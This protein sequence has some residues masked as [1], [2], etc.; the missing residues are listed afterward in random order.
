[1]SETRRRQTIDETEGAFRALDGY[2][3]AL[4]QGSDASQS[5]QR[6]H[7]P[8][9]DQ[10]QQDLQMLESLYDAAEMLRQDSLATDVDAAEH[11]DAPRSLLAPGTM[12]DQCRIDHLLGIGGMGEVY[13]AQHQVLACRVAVKVM[14]RQL[15][16]A[17]FLDRFRKEIQALA[18]VT[19]HPNITAAMHA[20]QYEDR[21][22][23]VTEYVDGVDLQ[24]LIHRHGPLPADQACRYI[25]QA[26]VG[27]A[28]AH[29]RGVV[30]R[31]IKPSNLM[32][33]DDDQIKILDMGLASIH[34][35][36][37]G[38]SLAMT[39]AGSLLGTLD[40]IAPEQIENPACAD[41]RS[42]L[43][44]LGCTFY[45]LLAGRPPYANLTPLQKISAHASQHPTS[46][47]KLGRNIPTSVIV[48]VETLMAKRPQDRYA[49]S[50]QLVAVLDGLT[51]QADEQRLPQPAGAARP[52]GMATAA[53]P[54]KPAGRP[55][56]RNLIAEKKRLVA[57]TAG[58]AVAVVVTATILWPR[59][60]DVT[61]PVESPAA[62]GL[63]TS[64][65]EEEPAPPIPLQRQ[66][67]RL[68]HP[69]VSVGQSLDT[70]EGT[71]P[72]ATSE[73]GRA[74]LIYV[75]STDSL[76]IRGDFEDEVHWYL[77]ATRDQ[78]GM[79]MLAHGNAEKRLAASDVIR[80][81]N[82]SDTTRWK[83][84]LLV[85]GSIP[86]DQADPYLQA[87]FQDVQG[88]L[89][90]L[91]IGVSS[92][93]SD[94][95]SSAEPQAV[96]DSSKGLAPRGRRFMDLAISRANERISQFRT[97]AVEEIL[98]APA[99]VPTAWDVRWSPGY[100]LIDNGLPEGL[101]CISVLGVRVV[102]E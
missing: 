44:S 58:L 68:L 94:A 78:G 29:Q 38:G 81:T 56:P 64:V 65:V 17:D 66:A 16:A 96:T 60:S 55:T 57:A 40:F 26:A 84:L 30:H 39:Q 67:P 36:G 63:T 14:Q 37:A 74:T 82:P 79:E 45:F 98:R 73:S 72:L 42:D 71:W 24:K 23:L 102:S 89:D 83:T 31:D 88:P 47:E 34:E 91:A 54:A 25:R 97:R 62:A 77:L 61:D 41:A 15:E 48:V 92:G 69:L 7:P 3:Q 86:V 59:S 27:L 20:S 87:Q 53:G 8:V 10:L 9:D 11:T 52:A 80:P 90:L 12:I 21:L 93:L 75:R 101:Y 46:L 51:G 35:A 32:R 100:P 13:L 43:Y 28:H 1:M 18:R 76:S 33:T 99:E 22:Y 95:D 5:W 85:A 49:S 6:D 2:W 70:A 4:Q 19:P 50:D